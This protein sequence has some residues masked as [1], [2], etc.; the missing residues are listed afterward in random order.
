MLVAQ[1]CLTLG[2]PMDCLLPGSSV[3]GILQARILDWVAI[4]FYRGSSQPRDWIWAPALHMDSLRSE[5][6]G[7]LIEKGTWKQKLD[8]QEPGTA[9]LHPIHPSPD[10]GGESPPFLGI[11]NAKPHP[12]SSS[13]SSPVLSSQTWAGEPEVRSGGVDRR[14][15]GQ[16]SA[17]HPR[18]GCSGPHLWLWVPLAFT[19]GGPV[20]LRLLLHTQLL[21]VHWFDF[22]L[23]QRINLALSRTATSGSAPA[24][25]PVLS[26]LCLP[27]DASG[28][29]HIW[30]STSV[31]FS[32]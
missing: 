27:V 28:P 29:G 31:Q 10:L 4:S 22:P 19:A 15:R 32:H 2:N 16:Q 30:Q 7:R 13:A 3:H 14:K 18:L 21:R 8:F 5:P 11:P 26:L 1:L 23:L 12:V 17:P 25:S 9:M 20:L 24:S 6:P